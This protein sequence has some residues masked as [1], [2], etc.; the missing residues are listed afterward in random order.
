MRANMVSKERGAEK[1]RGLIRFLFT[2][3]LFPLMAFAQAS[4][5]CKSAV[6]RAIIPKGATALTDYDVA[7][8]EYLFSEDGVDFYSATSYRRS[9]PVQWI[10]E[11]GLTAIIVYQDETTR[12]KQIEHLRE[13]NSLAARIGFPQ[14]LNNLKYAMINFFGPGSR[15]VRDLEYFEPKPCV[16]SSDESL[17]GELWMRYED[18]EIWRMPG[19]H[20]AK[21]GPNWLTGFY[22]PAL[23]ADATR[24]PTYARIH[25][26]MADKLR[27]YLSAHTDRR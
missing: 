25:N 24:N 15:F 16:T 11:N 19:L 14:R 5:T 17:A 27:I 3:A 7:P 23:I 8:L 13:S 12:L 22:T 6:G 18:F 1:M 10:R 20:A 2:I 26:V 21:N 4:D 9:D